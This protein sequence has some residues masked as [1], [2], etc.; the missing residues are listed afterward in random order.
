MPLDGHEG[1]ALTLVRPCLRE[2]RL[3]MVVARIA[4]T[5]SSSDRMASQVGSCSSYRHRVVLANR[6]T[7]LRKTV[8]TADSAE[9]ARRRP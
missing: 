1:T 3:V 4:V 5:A 8:G 7:G 6:S 9:M 2:A